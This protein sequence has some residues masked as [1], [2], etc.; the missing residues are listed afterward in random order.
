MIAR[1]WH[2]KTRASD[3]EAYREYVTA[4]GV[5][6]LRQTP[7]NRGV[8]LLRNVK[9]TEAEFLVISLWDSFDAIRA[10][11]GPDL[12]KARYFDQDRTFLLEFEPNVVHY[13]VLSAPSPS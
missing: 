3:G 9:E 13:E 6:E 5:R 4:S 1:I 8:Y 11:A 12:E 7:G 2:G 10:F